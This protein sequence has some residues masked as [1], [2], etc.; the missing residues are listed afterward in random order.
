[1]P[2]WERGKDADK[3]TVTDILSGQSSGFFLVETDFEIMT[4]ALRY[5]FS[6]ARQL[7]ILLDGRAAKRDVQRR[8]AILHNYGLVERLWGIYRTTPMPVSLPDG[9]I[10]TKDK[11]IKEYIFALSQKG[12]DLLVRSENEYAVA[13]QG[14]WQPKAWSSS[15]KNSLMHELGRNDVC[16]AML[17]ALRVLGRPAIDWRGPREAFHRYVPPAPGA[18]A[19]LAEPDS[20]LI[21][22]NGRPLFVEYERSGRPERFY[23]KLINMRTYI[24][25]NGWK[26]RYLGSPWIVYAIPVGLGTQKVTSGTY[27]GL[28]HQ[29]VMGNAMRYLLLDQTSWET[30]S[31]DAVRSD[32]SIVSLWKTVLSD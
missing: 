22:D 13:W 14:N 7:V 1:M 3:F 24:A 21:L 19:I 9:S 30:G 18:A 23:R 15:R 10:G 20:V 27:G 11:R 2:R 6:T 25:S 31:W 32:G 8:L 29:A 28:V 5:N 16:L 12:F 26:Q 17:Q 4:A